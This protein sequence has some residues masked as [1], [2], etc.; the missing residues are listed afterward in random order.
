MT[1]YIDG[2]SIIG[3]ITLLIVVPILHRSVN[4]I[5]FKMGKKKEPW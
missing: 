2:A 5:G 1:H 3:L 4:I